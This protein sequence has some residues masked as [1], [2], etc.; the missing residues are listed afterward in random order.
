MAPSRSSPTSPP[1]SA[2]G[3]GRPAWCAG[4]QRTALA[5]QRLLRCARELHPTR[6]VDLQHNVLPKCLLPGPQ[7]GAGGGILLI[8]RRP[9]RQEGG[10]FP[11]FQALAASEKHHRKVSAP[12]SAL[13]KP[14]APPP[15]NPHHP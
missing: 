15:S 4:R 5:Q 6:R 2:A 7:R 3:T 9:G 8:L 1:K 13:V 11:F 10:R 14:P 12:L